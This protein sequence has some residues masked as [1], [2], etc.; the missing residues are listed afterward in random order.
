MC[1]PLVL[2]IQLELLREELA[3]VRRMRLNVGPARI[4]TQL[5]ELLLLVSS[6]AELESASERTFA[7]CCQ[8]FETIRQEDLPGLRESSRIWTARQRAIEAVA[9]LEKALRFAR[10]SAEARRL[11]LDWP[12]EE[13]VQ[14]GCG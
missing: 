13:T 11:G 6:S 12:L 1:I 3:C 14:R 9:E 7:A 2:A 10:P 5:K 8:L 4:V